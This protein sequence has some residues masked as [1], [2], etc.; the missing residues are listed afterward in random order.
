M[1]TPEGRPAKSPTAQGLLPE[2]GKRLWPYIG[3]RFFPG[4]ISKPRDSFQKESLAYID[5]G[6]SPRAWA[7]FLERISSKRRGQE[8]CGQQGQGQERCAQER[9]EW[10]RGRRRGERTVG[11]GPQ[12]INTV[13]LA[14]RKQSD[15]STWASSWQ[16]DDGPRATIHGQ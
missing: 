1:H 15:P 16:R 13:Y 7:I 8:G 14:C 4:R 2:S 5:P 3:H 6:K 12:R 10:R 9:C 11:P